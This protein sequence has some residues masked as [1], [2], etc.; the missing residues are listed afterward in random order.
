MF[1]TR[2][3][4]CRCKSREKQLNILNLIFC[5]FP[6]PMIFS[7]FICAAS[8]MRSF[9]L[10]AWSS[11]E[12]VNFPQICI[13]SVIIIIIRAPLIWVRQYIIE[14]CKGNF[15]KK[16]MVIKSNDSKKMLF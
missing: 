2:V 4:Q 9:S 16:H 7:N 15:L 14:Q 8:F 3:Y 12:I 11:E 1:F 5:L 6:S 10:Y 13:I